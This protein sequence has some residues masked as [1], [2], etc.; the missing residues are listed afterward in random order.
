VEYL[1]ARAEPGHGSLPASFVDYVQKHDS[2][3]IRLKDA[4]YLPCT[5]AEGAPLELCNHR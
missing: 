4:G 5:T 2:A 1:Y 3:R